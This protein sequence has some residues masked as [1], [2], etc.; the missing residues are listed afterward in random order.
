MGFVMFIMKKNPCLVEENKHVFFFFDLLIENK[1]K[2]HDKQKK[3]INKRWA[4][5]L[6][7]TRKK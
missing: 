1:N 4:I 3:K 6:Q 2:K 5:R 7:S